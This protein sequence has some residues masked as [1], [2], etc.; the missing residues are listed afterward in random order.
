MLPGDPG[1]P[2]GGRPGAAH[3]ASWWVGSQADLVR[4][5]VSGRLLGKRMS[6]RR[7]P[8]RGSI[9]YGMWGGWRRRNG[10]FLSFSFVKEENSPMYPHGSPAGPH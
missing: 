8:Y 3:E 10:P 6:Q 7:K 1:W 5:T 2:C 9:R 4:V